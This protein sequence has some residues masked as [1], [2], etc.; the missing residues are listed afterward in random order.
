VK[1]KICF[2]TSGTQLLLRKTHAS[3]LPD[4]FRSKDLDQV[5]TS[6]LL[7]SDERANLIG[8]TCLLA[9]PFERFNRCQDARTRDDPFCNSI[10][11][12][13]VVRTHR[14]LHGTPRAVE[15]RWSG[16]MHGSMVVFGINLTEL[17]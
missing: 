12:R 10:A 14:A 17:S 1:R 7:L 9:L 3:T 4:G 6:G 13:N 8:C 16:K 15:V 11:K 5:S 2:I